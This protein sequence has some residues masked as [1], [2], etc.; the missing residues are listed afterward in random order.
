LNFQNEKSD[1]DIFYYGNN[2]KK[3]YEILSKLFKK[4][5]F[6]PIRGNLLR[7]L[8]IE[9]GFRNVIDYKIFKK[10]EKSKRIEGMFAKKFL[11]SIKLVKR[12][13]FK[14]IER[15]NTIEDKIKIIDASESYLWPAKYIVKSL[16]N[17]ETY[18]IITYRQRYA[19]ILKE[20][21]IAKIK[22][23]VEITEKGKIINIDEK[24]YIVPL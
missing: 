15:K 5:K 21:N 20:G 23:E 24:G 7:N 1:I 8:Y 17:D 19:E 18:S 6:L 22:G 11:F 10:I 16:K 2:Y 13:Y 3:V 12:R 9:R 14:I 4:R